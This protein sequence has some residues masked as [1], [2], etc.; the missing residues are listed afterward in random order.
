MRSLG[1]VVAE[2]RGVEVP[3]APPVAPMSGSRLLA[4]RGQERLEELDFSDLF[5]M[6]DAKYAVE[7]AA[8]GGHPVLL[9]G[10]KGAGKT[11][12]AERVPTILP[13]A[14]PGGVTRAHR[15]PLAGRRARARRRD[16]HHPAVLRRRTTTPAR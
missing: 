2:L 1:Q 15:H 9:T 6:A 7:V 5:G 3:E 16:A 8:A 10:P 14:D 12:L 4:W 11:S 13:R